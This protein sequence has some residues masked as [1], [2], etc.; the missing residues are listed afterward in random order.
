MARVTA[1]Q[2]ADKLIRRLSAAGEDI[3]LGVESVTESPTRA[4]AAKKDKMRQNILTAIDNGKWEA[5]LNRVT[6]EDWKTATVNKGIPRIS[7]GIQGAKNKLTD[8]YGKLL[9]FQDAL[10][11]KVK[12]MPD[13]TLDDSINRMTTFIKGMAQFKK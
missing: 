5:G 10:A 13:L 11:A 6:V 7:A 8:F 3:R 4:A 9:P 1:E 12:K 2:A